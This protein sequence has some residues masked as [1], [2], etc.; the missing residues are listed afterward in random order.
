MNTLNNAQRAT[1]RRKMFALLRHARRL[2]EPGY[3]EGTDRWSIAA[4]RIAATMHNAN[5][6]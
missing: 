3:A 5:W 1:L 4:R 6:S 2:N